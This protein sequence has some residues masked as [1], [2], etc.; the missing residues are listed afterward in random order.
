MTILEQENRLFSN[1]TMRRPN[2]IRDGIV[3]DGLY[4]SNEPKLLFLL[5]EPNSDETNWSLVDFLRKGAQPATWDNITRWII[6]IRNLQKDISWQQL[7]TISKDQRSE[8]LQFIAAMNFK[9][10]GGRDTVNEKELF[11]F[12][13]EDKEF[14]V[15]QF[16]LYNNHSSDHLTICCGSIIATLFDLYISPNQQAWRQTSRGV[17]FR[18]YQSRKFVILYAHPEARVAD[19]ILYYPLIDA[20]KEILSK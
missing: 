8:E 1:W 4:F 16:S 9:K 13:A 10:T 18:E 14:L 6:G 2:I 7:S 17:P 19:Y 15:E 11:R 3:N 20:V 12:A 5:K